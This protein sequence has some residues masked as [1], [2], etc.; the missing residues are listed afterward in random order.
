MK[1]EVRVT[2]KADVFDDH[3]ESHDFL[4]PGGTLF[5]SLAEAAGAGQDGFQDVVGP[6]WTIKPVAGGS[7]LETSVQTLEGPRRIGS[8]AELLEALDR[9]TAQPSP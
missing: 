9:L 3:F 8:L 2:T 5:Q 4:S 7:L 1:A 6:C